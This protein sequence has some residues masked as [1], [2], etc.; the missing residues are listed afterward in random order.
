LEKFYYGISG[1]GTD[2]KIPIGTILVS[3]ASLYSRGKFRIPDIV[4]EYDE[5]MLDWGGYSWFHSHDAYPFTPMEYWRFVKDFISVYP[6]TTYVAM[7]DYPCEPSVLSARAFSNKC[8]IHSSIQNFRELINLPIEAEWM[9]VVQGYTRSEYSYCAAL[10]HKFRLYTPLTAIGSVCQRKG[11]GTIKEI[12][13]H[14][15][16]QNPNVDYHA[17]GLQIRALMDQNTKDLLYSSD[18][19]VWRFFTGAHKPSKN[20]WK[21]RNID[22]KLENYYRYRIKIEE[23]VLGDCRYRNLAEAV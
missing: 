16:A 20:V 12:I 22:E 3:V 9:A 18:S 2:L 8:R 13:H 10:L 11:T 1:T 23:N 19:H 14:V 17:F 21:P 15:V 7:M 4:G 5:I 6:K